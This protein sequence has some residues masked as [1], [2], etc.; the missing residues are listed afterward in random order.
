MKSRRSP[1][2]SDLTDDQWHRLEPLLPPIP[3]AGRNRLISPRQVANAINYRWE[4][5]CA[6][7]MLPHDFPAWQ[8]V[9]AYFRTWQ[10]AGLIR[11]LRE[12]LLEPRPK[13]RSR[14]LRRPTGPQLRNSPHD[15]HC[16][17]RRDGPVSGFSSPDQPREARPGA[18]PAVHTSPPPQRE[19]R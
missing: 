9:Y 15:L 5:G 7:R 1:Y 6:W 8:T 4:T 16:S 3:E 18:A 13:K 14:G 12:M 17:A 2:P 19:P 11:Q 10:K